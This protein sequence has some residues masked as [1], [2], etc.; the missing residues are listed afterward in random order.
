[1]KG[2]LARGKLADLVLLDCDIFEID[3]ARID[4][5]RVRIPRR[6]R[7]LNPWN[8]K[9]RKSLIFKGAILRFMG[10]MTVVDG[11]LVWEGK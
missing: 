11:K 7:A 9:M 1:M 10:R 4:Q 3:P 8:L 2:S 6:I 5:V